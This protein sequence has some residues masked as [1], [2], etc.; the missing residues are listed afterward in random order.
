[1]E[2]TNNPKRFLNFHVLFFLPK[3]PNTRKC[4]V[5]PNCRLLKYVE[6]KSQK[7]KK[8]IALVEIIK[9]KEKNV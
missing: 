9:Q 4:P 8:N 2:N 3:C 6:S 7:L 5:T 1:M